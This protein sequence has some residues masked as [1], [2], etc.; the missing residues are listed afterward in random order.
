MGDAGIEDVY[1]EKMYWGED[2]AE[3]VPC[4]YHSYYGKILVCKKGFIFYCGNSVQEQ[5]GQGVSVEWRQ[6]Q[7]VEHCQDEV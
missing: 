5:V 3:E 1:Y 6:W 7:E 4:D 2:I